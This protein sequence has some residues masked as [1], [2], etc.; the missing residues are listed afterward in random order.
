MTHVEM[1]IVEDAFEISGRGVVVTPDFPAPRGWRNRSE[2]VTIVKPDGQRYETVARFNLSHFNSTASQISQDVPWRVAV[3]LPDQAK[4][5]LPPGS[6]ILVT[7]ET[8][9]AILAQASD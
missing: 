6:I 5:D 4:A 3:T 2:N 7:P 1:L 8:R 9:D